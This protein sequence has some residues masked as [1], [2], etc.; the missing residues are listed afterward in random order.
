VKISF[1][2]SKMQSETLLEYI[3]EGCYTNDLALKTKLS[4]PELMELL[5]SLLSLERIELLT[6][7]DKMFVK[8][9]SI[10]ESSKYL[11]MN[12]TERKVYEL[13]KQTG[14][15]GCWIKHIKDKSQLHTK[16]VNDA[17]KALEKKQIIKT[18]KS[19]KQPSKKVYILYEIEPSV[20]LTGG[21]WYTDQNMDMEFIDMLALL[22][23]RTVEKQ[24]TLL[25]GGVTCQQAHEIVSKTGL[26]KQELS[27]GDVETLL[28]RLVYDDHVRKLYVEGELVYRR[29]QGILN[30]NTLS[31]SVCGQCPVFE[32]CSDH[33]NVTPFTCTYFNK[34]V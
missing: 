31:E 24:S 32:L 4:Q 6:Q 2:Q 28:E 12:S 30:R 22:V 17:I 26:S 1:P 14:E 5:N 19:V 11:V 29:R 18:V 34:W 8:P 10:K 27:I 13:I 25:T 9:R 7:G 20:E 21:S 33:G 16:I 23:L 15:N 3:E